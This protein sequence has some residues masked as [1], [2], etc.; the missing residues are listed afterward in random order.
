MAG[1]VYQ[2]MGCDD[3]KLPWRR[4]EQDSLWTSRV[5]DGRN[6]RTSRVTCRDDAGRAGPLT[7]RQQARPRTAH[8]HLDQVQLRA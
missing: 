6:A 7:G 2:K 1:A 8:H 4:P 5:G 3:L